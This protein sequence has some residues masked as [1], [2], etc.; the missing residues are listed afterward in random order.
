[1]TIARIQESDE[2]EAVQNAIKFWLTTGICSFGEV[3][4]IGILFGRTI[5]LL[6]QYYDPKLSEGEVLG[7]SKG[8][9]EPLVGFAKIVAGL[10]EITEII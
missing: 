7:W 9:L 5:Y 4:L 10:S 3:T 1:M 6:I 8:Y 2:A